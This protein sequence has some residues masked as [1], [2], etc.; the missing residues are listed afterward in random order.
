MHKYANAARRKRYATVAT[1]V[2][3]AV[4]I[5]AVYTFISALDESRM[6]SQFKKYVKNEISSNDK[7]QLIDKNLDTKTK[8]ISL[9]FFNEISEAEENMLQNQLLTILGMQI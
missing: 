8:V 7:Y 1:V 3:I 5:P 6:N 4:M 9:N 2:G